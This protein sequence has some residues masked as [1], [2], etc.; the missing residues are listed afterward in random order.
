MLDE[1]ER[2][3]RTAPPRSVEVLVHRSLDW[4]G[5]EHRALSS[6]WPSTRPARRSPSPCSRTSGRSRRT[7][8][9]KRSGSWS[10]LALPSRSGSGPAH[11]RAARPHHRLAAPRTRRPRRRSPPT[12]PPAT[13]RAVLSS[14]WQPRRAHA[15]DRAEWLAYHLVAAGAWDRLKALPTLRWRS[16]FLVAT[17]SDAAFLAGLDHYGHAALAQAPDGRL[18]RRA[19]LAFRGPRQDPDRPAS[20]LRARGHGAGRR[21]D[22][23]DHPSRPASGGSRRHIESSLLLVSSGWPSFL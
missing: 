9:G 7:R 10:G 19:G 16:A 13:G 8:H 12:G 22:R 20:H 2:T 17:G 14:R 1:L 11:D 18:P 5:P 4:L 23:C 3:P 21:S 15:K 6:C